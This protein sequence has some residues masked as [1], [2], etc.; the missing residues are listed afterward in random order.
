MTH[1]EKDLE[2]RL[3]RIE[4]TISQ[5]QRDIEVLEDLTT[6]MERYIMQMASNQSLIA[7]KITKWPYVVIE[8]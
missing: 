1:T 2:V 4:M 6:K 5:M 8:N 3:K 7:E